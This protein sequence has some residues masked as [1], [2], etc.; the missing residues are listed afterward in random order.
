MLE[1]C[2]VRGISHS[3]VNIIEDARIEKFVKRKYAGLGP[4]FKRGYRDLIAK[5]FFG[6]EE[7]GI[8]SF[9]FID[10][11]NIFFKTDD[12]SVRFSEK[13]MPFVE[14]TAKVE[15]EDEVL[16]LAEDIFKFM[17]E[18]PESNGEENTDDADESAMGNPVDMTDGDGEST[19]E[20]GKGNAPAGA[21]MDNKSQEI[22]DL[23]KEIEKALGDQDGMEADAYNAAM[24]KLEKLTQ[25]DGDA[26]DG[27][28]DNAGPTDSTTED[29]STEGGV[30]RSSGG[31]VPK[32]ETDGISEK[33]LDNLRN[34]GAKDREYAKIPKLDSTKYIVDYKTI[35]SA[36]GEH[37]SKQR[38]ENKC[39]LFWTS[40]L[41]E[42][43]SLKSDS[44]KTVA[45]MVKEFE[46]KKSA[47]QYAR[48]STAKTGTLDMSKIHTYK[49]NDDLFKKVTTLPGATNHGL[50][51]VVDWSGSM[52]ENL[53]GTISQLFNLVWFC[54]RSQ[55]PFEVFAFSDVRNWM[56]VDEIHVSS[57]EVKQDFRAGDLKLRDFNLLNFFSSK[58]SLSEENNM[59]HILWMFCSRWGGY[60]DW[61]NGGYP[62]ATPR[63][64]DMG[65]TPL[66]DAIIT[67]MDFVPK[68]KLEAGVQ[69]VNTIFL[70]DGA[71]NSLDGVMDL[72][73]QQD[74][75][76]HIET[77]NNFSRGGRLES[78]ITDPVT[79]KTYIVPNYEDITNKL[80]EILKNRVEGMNVVGFFLAGT[81]R[82][83]RIDK[84]TL[85]YITGVNIHSEE[86]RDMLRKVNKEKFYAVTG[87]ITGYDEYYILAGGKSLTPENDTLDDELA[88]ASKAKLKTAFGKMQKSK[89]GSRVLLNRFVKMVA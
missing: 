86:M 77:V 27:E 67:M 41:S 3:F 37:Y 1:K 81:G 54:R 62:Y 42:V 47:D 61:A 55:I 51:M 26:D 5:D 57:D 78:I 63:W 46:M 32:A 48:A 13:E 74:T 70:T 9:G 68:F 43:E 19:G 71:S 66:N 45:Y 60:R 80:L 44:K 83:G 50:V 35:L 49:F 64:L 34:K 87:E 88:G 73:L 4:L 12:A 40:T 79:N 11:I 10:R 21:E 89:I 53:K 65:G 16:D 23:V 8:E 59:M 6:T 76:E 2:A 33:V 56:G 15:T 18:N 75:G 84:R 29:G 85:S 31:G 82:S 58:M 30:G 24:D 7:R 17:E 25:N 20:T 69:K 22:K 36:A 52:H 72:Q 14:R 28:A 39:D 38:K